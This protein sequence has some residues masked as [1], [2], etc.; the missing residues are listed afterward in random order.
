MKKI[1]IYSDGAEKTSMLKMAKEPFISG[2]TTN[3]SLMKKAGLKDY[4]AFAKDILESSPDKSFSFEVFADDFSG[5]LRQAKEINSWRK[6]SKSATNPIYVKIPITNSEGKSCIPLVKELAHSGVQLNVTAI[7]TT[8]QVQETCDAVKGGAPSIVSVFAGR[9]ADTGR[10]PMPMM[11]DYLKICRAADPK[12]IELLWASCR[13]VL[14]IKQA[15][16]CGSD[17]IT[18]PPEILSKLAMAGRDLDKLSLDT[19][20][21]FRTDSLAAGFSI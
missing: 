4:A 17:I 20:Q 19:V 5:M 12:N 11:R 6:Y 21:M 18:V 14:N 2:F 9:I 8:K 15:E 3:P 13:E 1:K 10:D 7:F 16:E